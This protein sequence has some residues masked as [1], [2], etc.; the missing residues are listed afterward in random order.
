MIEQ[1]GR[2]NN[3]EISGIP[4][5]LTQD[6]LEE[7]VVSAFFETGIALMPNDINDC[8]RNERSHD[9]PKNN[10]LFYKW[11]FFQTSE[12]LKPEKTKID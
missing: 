3:F 9:K 6:C 10:P 7:K 2:R 5:N 11:D 4:D 8:Y 1:Y 12:K